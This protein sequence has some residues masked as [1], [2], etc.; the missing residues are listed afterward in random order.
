MLQRSALRA[1][2]YS[3]PPRAGSTSAGIA[4]RAT[5]RISLRR[6]FATTLAHN[7]DVP[8]YDTLVIGAGH[9]GCEAAAASARAGARTL[10]LTQKL[11]TIGGESALARPSCPVWRVLTSLYVRRD[12]LQPQ[13]WRCVLTSRLYASFSG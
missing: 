3:V 8:P 4:V 10:L 13:L 9:A 1:A 6:T 7:P 2:L 11:E 12:E 5:A